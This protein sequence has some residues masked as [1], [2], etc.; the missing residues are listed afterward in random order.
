MTAKAG[1]FTITRSND[2]RASMRRLL[3]DV[4]SYY[5]IAYSRPTAILDGR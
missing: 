4:E 1:G 2:V 3:E 5:Q